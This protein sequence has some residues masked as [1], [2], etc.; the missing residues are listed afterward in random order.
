MRECA[1]LDGSW[2][3]GET[4]FHLLWPGGRLGHAILVMSQ[5]VIPEVDCISTILQFHLEFL[6]NHFAFVKHDSVFVGS[7]PEM[8]PDIGFNRLGVFQSWGSANVA[9]IVCSHVHCFELH[10]TRACMHE[11]NDTTSVVKDYQGTNCQGTN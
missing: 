8:L 4:E 11:F 1:E 2:R 7:E 6:A 3:I 9:T 10:A 5:Y